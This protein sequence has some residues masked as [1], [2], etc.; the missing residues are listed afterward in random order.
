CDKEKDESF[1]LLNPLESIEQL[2]DSSFMSN[3]SRLSYY[4]GLIYL[5]DY[6]NSRIVCMDTSFKVIRTMG[7]NGRGPGEFQGIV[8]LA[9][10][11]DT[12][13]ALDDGN[14]RINVFTIKGNYL[15]DVAI[16]PIG[17]LSTRFTVDK[18]G[19]FYISSPSD[20]SFPIT[21]FDRSGK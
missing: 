14:R 19:Y 12:I 2:S 4:D 15:G 18:E 9:I 8:S 6:N 16:P 13:Y 7:R 5:C 21:K 3:G 10:I 11:N 20:K 1:Q 17:F